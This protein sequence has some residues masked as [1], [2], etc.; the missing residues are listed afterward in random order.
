MGYNFDPELQDI[1][2]LLPVGSFGDPVAAR[3]LMVDVVSAM[4]ACLDFSALDIDDRRIA[5][6]DGSADVTGGSQTWIK[7]ELNGVRLLSGMRK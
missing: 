3:V 7:S 1:I 4:N 2:P 6:C 5:G